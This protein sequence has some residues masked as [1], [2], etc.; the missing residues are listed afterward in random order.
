MTVPPRSWECRVICVDHSLWR[1]QGGWSDCFCCCSLVEA[2]D[3][4]Q[5]DE[6]SHPHRHETGCPLSCRN[7]SSTASIALGACGPAT[8]R[9][10]TRLSASPRSRHIVFGGCVPLRTPRSSGDH[11]IK[12]N[13]IDVSTCLPPSQPVDRLSLISYSCHP[14]SWHHPN[15]REPP[16]T[17]SPPQNAGLFLQSFF[18]HSQLQPAASG[19]GPDSLLPSGSE[20]RTPQPTGH[21]NV[22]SHQLVSQQG[23]TA[24]VAAAAA[25]TTPST[26]VLAS[27]QPSPAAAA[28]SLPSTMHPS[29]HCPAAPISSAAPGLPGFPLF[30]FVQSPMQVCVCQTGV[31]PAGQWVRPLLFCVGMSVRGK[32]SIQHDMQHG[33]WISGGVHSQ[34]LSCDAQVIKL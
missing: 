25:A 4:Q 15:H 20:P 26:P 14:Q 3:P 33:E 2:N 18:A 28:A 27:A 16:P 21:S 32:V 13:V 12:A 23:G 7:S 22:D 5:S 29:C 34:T 1:G 24:G 19:P 9:C 17:A 31:H 11:E 8:S 10:K 6:T 30:R